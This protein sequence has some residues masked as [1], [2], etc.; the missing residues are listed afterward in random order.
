[1][2][3]D[4]VPQSQHHGA[5]KH[6]SALLAGPLRCGRCGRKLTVRY[7]GK[8]HDIPRYSCWRGLLDN[9][10]ARCIAFG[11][12]RVD[13]SIEHA[14]LQMVSPGAIAAAEAAARQVVRQRGQVRDVLCRDLAAAQY[15]TDQA[16]R[17]YDASHPEN[18]L[19]T[20]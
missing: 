13:D 11:G 1:M 5:A 9:G 17:Q 16:F 2:V 18:R 19:V 8:K 20:A 6:G 14:L 4:N 12:L 3:S 15:A 10:D 7:N